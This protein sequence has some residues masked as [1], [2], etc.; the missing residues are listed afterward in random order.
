MEKD[1]GVLLVRMCSDFN[2]DAGISILK[3][4]MKY[5]TLAMLEGCTLFA[6]TMCYHSSPI[7]SYLLE[8]RKVGLHL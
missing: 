4:F 2:Y 8:G 6:L 5:T 1:I 3:T 7:S